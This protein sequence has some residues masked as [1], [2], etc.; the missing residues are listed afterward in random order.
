MA[1]IRQRCKICNLEKRCKIIRKYH[2]ITSDC[3]TDYDELIAEYRVLP[4]QRGKG[5]CSGSNK[6]DHVILE[7]DGEPQED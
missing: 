3:H 7:I 5:T 4:H 6:I 1:I 2:E